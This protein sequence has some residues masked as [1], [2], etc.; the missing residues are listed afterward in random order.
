MG[1]HEKECILK[2]WECTPGGFYAEQ[3]YRRGVQQA[4]HMVWDEL[5]R[6]LSPDESGESFLFVLQRAAKIAGDM[7]F[8]RVKHPF[9]M[10]ELLAR[11][12]DDQFAEET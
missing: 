11:L 1:T 3:A 8:D 4:L 2:A 6:L 10:D 9:Y 12:R 7:R 5:S